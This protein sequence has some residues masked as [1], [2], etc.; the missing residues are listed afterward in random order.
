MIWSCH[1]LFVVMANNTRVKKLVPT[2]PLST[3]QRMLLT[4]LDNEIILVSENNLSFFM[5]EFGDPLL[6]WLYPLRRS[7]EVFVGLPRGQ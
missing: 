7:C 5:R 2:T 1:D 4:L 3:G 6:S